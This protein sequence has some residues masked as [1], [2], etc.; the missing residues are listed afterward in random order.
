MSNT[1]LNTSEHLLKG[2]LAVAVMV[3]LFSM[4]ITTRAENAYL[5]GELD[6]WGGHF[7]RGDDYHYHMIPIIETIVGKE[8]PLAYALDGYPIYGYT[9]ETLDEGLDVMM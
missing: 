8:K 9:E 2:A 5:I 6:D 7:G 1:P 4:F 3:F